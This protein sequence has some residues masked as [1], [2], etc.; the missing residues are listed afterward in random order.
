M[1]SRSPS[2]L[3]TVNCTSDRPGCILRTHL[4]YNLPRIDVHSLALSLAP[5]LPFSRPACVLPPQRCETRFAIAYWAFSHRATRANLHASLTPS[6]PRS[7]KVH[8]IVEPKKHRQNQTHNV[9][10]T[11]CPRAHQPAL[12]CQPAHQFF[13]ILHLF[14]SSGA[15]YALTPQECLTTTLQSPLSVLGRSGGACKAPAPSDAKRTRRT[16]S[17][18]E[19]RP[20][21]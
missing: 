8:C 15:K 17:R 3:H 12:H 1:L 7:V 18:A 20:R 11:L 16:A 21:R 5:I 9:S 6:T 14:R 13:N 10:S 4:A 19:R 2:T